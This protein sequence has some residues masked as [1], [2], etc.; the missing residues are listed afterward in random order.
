MEEELT[1]TTTTKID[2]MKAIEVCSKTKVEE[3]SE[4]EATDDSP[5]M[6]TEGDVTSQE[7]WLKV[8]PPNTNKNHQG[9]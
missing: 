9:K 2:F 6:E 8:M 1:T 4:K 7:P 3:S 5:G